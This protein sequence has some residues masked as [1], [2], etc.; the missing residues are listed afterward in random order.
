MSNVIQVLE[1]VGISHSFP[2]HTMG[3][4]AVASVLLQRSLYLARIYRDI[5]M[6]RHK[7]P[8]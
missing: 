8:C 3:I 1:V 5:K 4:E 7:A 6:L 2:M